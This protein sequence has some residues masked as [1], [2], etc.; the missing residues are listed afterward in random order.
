MHS[1]RQSRRGKR[2]KDRVEDSEKKESVAGVTVTCCLHDWFVLLLTFSSLPLPSQTNSLTTQDASI[3]SR[4]LKSLEDP[5]FLNQHRRFSLRNAASP[6]PSEQDRSMQ[7][8]GV[9]QQ[10]CDSAF[11]T[12]L[13]N[14]K[15]IDC[16]STL[17][18]EGIDW[19]SVTP[20]TP[21]ADVTK[22]LFDGG[23]CKML[24]GD[25][26][27]T[28]IFCSTFDSCVV[29]DNYSPNK[30]AGG[31][32]GS[33]AAGGR[34][35]TIDCSTLKECNWDGFHHSFLGD[36]NCHDIM[37]G[38]YNTEICGFDGGDCCEDTCVSDPEFVICGTDG[39]ACRDPT[40]KLC[41]PS[42]TSKCI[43]DYDNS[44]DETYTIDCSKGETMYRLIMYDSFGDGWDQTTL[45][46][47]A[48]EDLGK[49][50]FTG[51][52]KS[53]AQGTEFIC[54]S[55]DPK[56]YQID[57][58]GGT[59]GNE[60]SWE[61]KALGE[62]T[63]ALADGGSPTQCNFPIGGNSCARTCSGKPNIN[64]NDDPDYKTYKDMFTCIEAKCLIQVGACKADVTCAPCFNPDAPE[65][66]FANDNFNAVIDCGLCTCG[67]QENKEF[68]NSKATPGAI[69]PLKPLKPDE[70]VAPKACTA[71]E[72]LKGASSVMAFA[73]CSSFDQI[74]MM[75]T[76]FDENN[77]GAL[78]S[79]EACAHSFKNEASHGGRTALGCMTILYNAIINPGDSSSGVPTDAIASLANLLYHDA[80]G[81]CECTS[82]ANADCPLCPS[83][84]HFK[85]LLYESLDACKSLDE[86]DCDAWNEFYTPCKKNVEEKFGSV[87]FTDHNQCKFLLVCCIVSST[88][89]KNRTEP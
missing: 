29:W 40:S 13:P 87:D 15:C 10:A 73:T 28:N 22:F 12:C 83:F 27:A 1:L 36:G 60:V 59:W 31:S 34:N 19:A 72:T 58:K 65:F 75:V 81:F 8:G 74:G 57:V 21:C 55:K 20:G 64:P 80:E 76:D 84:H 71:A 47:A 48:K 63:P 67:D 6:Q 14:D 38:C 42:L 52:L 25:V 11:M 30:D 32:G 88:S 82:K 4:R 49:I 16:F 45:T 78:D 89:Q 54:L 5:S 44:D 79:F 43:P 23:H 39:F 17:Q 24:Q 86:I 53:G 62:G 18:V 56:C 69:S 41:D 37:P 85:T 2:I 51:G 68:C 33:A 26:G 3:L 61:V 77:F 50:I 66:C 35:G 46:I 9:T 7:S 70:P